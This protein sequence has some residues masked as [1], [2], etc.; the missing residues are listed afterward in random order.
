MLSKKLMKISLMNLPK[1]SV[2]SLSS[3]IENHH[4]TITFPEYN[5]HGWNTIGKSLGSLATSKNMSLKADSKITESEKSSFITTLLMRPFT[6]QSQ[7]LK[8]QV[9]HRECS[10]KDKKFPESLDNWLIITHGEISM[11]ELT[12][13]SM[14]EFSTFMIVMALQKSFTI[15][16]KLLWAHQIQ[17]QLICSMSS[18]EQKML[19]LIHLIPKSTKST[20]KSSLEVGIQMMDSKSIWIM[21]EESFLSRFSGVTIRLKA[22]PIISP[23]ITSW[24]T[25]MLKLRKSDSRIQE[26]ILSHSCSKSKNYQRSQHKL[27]TQAWAW[28]NNNFTHQKISA[29]E[30]TFM[31][32]E[33][34]VSF[35]TVI[36]LPKVITNRNSVLI[37]SLWQLNKAKKEWYNMR[38][39]H[40]LVMVLQ[41]TVWEVFIHFSP[42]HQKK[43]WL[44]CLQTTSIHWDMKPEWFLK[45][46]IKMTESS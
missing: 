24:L 42:N 37:W 45:T 33:E 13:I 29:L 15:T 7:R 26:K 19:K 18:R 1:A 23:S 28:Q 12:L 20:L 34:I 8:I 35:T 41:R 32:L 46:G 31:Y 6:S 2:N 30:L 11:L 21:T 27:V 10:W 38:F 22:V 5:L 16:W 14:K 9:F 25:I 43:T 36:N 3:R 40:T 44:N 17:S 39:L 4:K